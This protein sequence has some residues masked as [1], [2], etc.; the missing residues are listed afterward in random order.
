MPDIVMW[1]RRRTSSILTSFLLV[2]R[3]SGAT[4]TLA[5]PSESFPK[6][7]SVQGSAQ[8]GWQ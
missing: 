1:L 8:R 3:T 7:T 6:M 5:L 4:M 2:K